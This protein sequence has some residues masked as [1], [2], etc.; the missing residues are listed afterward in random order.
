[1]IEKEQ[2]EKEEIK[3]SVQ[4]LPEVQ[5][6]LP[7]VEAE[8]PT[9]IQEQIDELK[10]SLEQLPE[11]SDTGAQ[12][13]KVV[14]ERIKKYQK[15]YLPDHLK[16][17]HKNIISRGIESLFSFFAREAQG[18]ENIPEDGPFL[19][20]SNHFGPE[21]GTIIKN[22]KD[23]N[24][25]MVIGKQI[26]WERSSLHKWFFKKMGMISANE[27]LTNISKEEKEA[28]LARQ[29]AYGQKVF[30][31][32]IDQEERGNK[33]FDTD[34]I[35]QSVALLSRGDVI[36]MLP[37]GLWLNP[38]GSALNPREKAEMKQ[39]YGGF[40][41]IARQYKKLTGKD[42][43]ILPTAFVDDKTTGKKEFHVGAP[44]IL[45]ENDSGLNN[46]DWCMAHIAKMLPESQRG[47]YKEA[48]ETL[49]DE[50]NIL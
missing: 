40:E 28:A 24:L 22:F 4:E 25:R 15:K 45:E 16:T 8:N 1:M 3:T 29:D 30:R 23:Y 11:E 10:N 41:L 48:T 6:E 36:C 7:K 44:L 27:S 5:L 2:H 13:T 37:E 50:H 31:K 33:P 26:W 12:D 21:T 42:L 47:Y 32:I 46:T 38:E 20:I 18:K 17:K 43:P 14:A 49:Q 34:F 35:R 39:G 19:V 9:E